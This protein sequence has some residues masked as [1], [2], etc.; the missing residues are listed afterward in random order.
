[1]LGINDRNVILC[2]AKLTSCSGEKQRGSSQN[3]SHPRNW[4]PGRTDEGFLCL[5]S[6]FVC[7][8]IDSRDE[9]GKA[10]L[11]ANTKEYGPS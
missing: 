3:L 2:K 6:G 8:R 5:E 4:C 10:P 9:K 7:R 1:M 11:L